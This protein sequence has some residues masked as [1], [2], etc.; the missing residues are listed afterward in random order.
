[1]YSQVE[2]NHYYLKTTIQQVDAKVD[3]N[4][5]EVIELLKKNNES[6]SLKFQLFQ[7]ES[8]ERENVLLAKISEI[9]IKNWGFIRRNNSRKKKLIKM[10]GKSQKLLR[11]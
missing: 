4:H 10:N 6:L 3:T 7:Q 8:I 9:E 1:M 5:T 11:L 2:Q